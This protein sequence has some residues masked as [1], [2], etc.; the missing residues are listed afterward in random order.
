ML[1]LVGLGNPG[2]ERAGNRH[3][4]GFMAADAIARTHGF[5]PWRPRFEAM[6]AEG[7]LDGHKTLLLKPMTYMNNSGRAVSQA[8]RFYKLDLKDVAVIYD[9][10]DLVQGK[11]RV[12]TGGGAAGHNGIRDIDAAI[13]PDFRRV[14]LG[15]GHPGHKDAV[16]TYVLKDFAKSDKAWLDPLLD[17]V[18]DAAP[19]LARH[20]DPGFATRVA[21]LTQP[22][23]PAKEPPVAPKEAKPKP[24]KESK[25]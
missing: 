18:A 16:L 15:I 8:V 12:K 10:L 2:P 19:Y 1:L 22:A 14:R 11:V 9:E 24:Q 23:K 7:L 13:G 3:N 17:A 21:L 4:I 20:D 5:G 6:L 25:E